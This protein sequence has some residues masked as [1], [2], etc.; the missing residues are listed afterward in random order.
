M[1][2]L[3]DDGNGAGNGLIFRLLGCALCQDNARFF[4]CC[5]DDAGTNGINSL[6]LGAGDLI[7]RLLC[8]TVEREFQFLRGRFTQGSGI[9]LSR[10]DDGLSLF[11]QLLLLALI[12]R[13]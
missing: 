11:E 3:P 5:L 10:L 2:L 12:A 7:L 1:N 4:C 13:E 9:P 6:G 8:P